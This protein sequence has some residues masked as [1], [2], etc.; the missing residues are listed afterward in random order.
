MRVLLAR[1]LNAL[2]RRRRLAEDESGRILFQFEQDAV[3]CFDG[4]ADV[5]DGILQWHRSGVI[6]HGLEFQIRFA[7]AGDHPVGIRSDRFEF[8][9]VDRLAHI[10]DGF[11]DRKSVV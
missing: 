4:L 7:E 6:E 2:C 3:E 1:G 8:H 9:A 11:L 5:A 10:V